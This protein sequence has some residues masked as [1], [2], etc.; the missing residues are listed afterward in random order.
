MFVPGLAPF[1]C[2]WLFSGGTVKKTVPKNTIDTQAAATTAMDS[3]SEALATSE[4]TTTS[5]VSA[6]PAAKYTADEHTA[7]INY[8]RNARRAFRKPGVSVEEEFKQWQ[9]ARAQY[10][11]IL[12]Q[13]QHPD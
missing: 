11:A 3:M 8:L 9:A 12:A 5:V 7:W 4:I 1:E 2:N 10:K 6:V 13:N